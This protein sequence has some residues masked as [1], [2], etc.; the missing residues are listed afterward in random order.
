V[1]RTNHL[2]QFKNIQVNQHLALHTIPYVLIIQSPLHEYEEGAKVVPALDIENWDE[3][4]IEGL[5]SARP[6]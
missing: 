1:I 3:V 6:L 5:L 2:A 4:K